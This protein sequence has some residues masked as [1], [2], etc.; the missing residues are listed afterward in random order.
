[1]LGSG[2]G[3]KFYSG[4][5]ISVVKYVKVLFGVIIGGIVGWSG[6]RVVVSEVCRGIGGELNI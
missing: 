4:Y 2:V 6:Y 1:M 5:V 3:G